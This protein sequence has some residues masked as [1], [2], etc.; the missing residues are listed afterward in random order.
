M[1]K[2]KMNFIL[3]L[4]SN[5]IFLSITLLTVLFRLNCKIP[6]SDKANNCK[7]EFITEEIIVEYNI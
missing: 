5:S 6:S 4:L 1:I 2:N 3:S 7:S